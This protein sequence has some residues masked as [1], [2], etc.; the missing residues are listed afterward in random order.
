MRYDN[1]HPFRRQNNALALQFKQR[2]KDRVCRCCE[3]EK[4]LSEFYHE[5]TRDTYRY[6]CKDCENQKR[7]KG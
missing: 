7:K 2:K 4:P 6:V 3:K 5:K 1:T